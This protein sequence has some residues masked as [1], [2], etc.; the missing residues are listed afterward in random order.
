[1]FGGTKRSVGN[2]GEKLPQ[3]H[4]GLPDSTFPY[5]LCPRCQKQSSFE[6]VGTQAVTFDPELI[7]VGRS[8]APARVHVDQVAILYC[9]NCDQGVVVIEEQCVADRSWREGRAGGGAIT[10]RGFHWWPTPDVHT[11]PDVPI[12]IADAFQEA[13]RSLHANCPRASVVMARRT[14]EAI[15]DDQG[16]ATGVLADRLKALAANG[17]LLPTLADWAKEVRLVG[18]TGAHFD[19]I[20]PASKEDA[21]QLVAFVRELLRYLYELPAELK[22][23]RSTP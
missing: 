12:A 2:T 17:V 1:M 21:Q 16:Q 7:A 13:V 15:T 5:G 20:N 8:E 23:R 4:E 22:R 14:L 6:V 19:P 11:S 10:W 9:R 18:N 3:K